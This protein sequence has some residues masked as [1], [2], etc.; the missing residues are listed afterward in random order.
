MPRLASPPAIT[1]SG[2]WDDEPVDADQ[3]YYDSLDDV[4]STTGMVFL[5]TTMGC[6]R[7]HDHKIDPIPQTRL[8]SD[9]GVLSQHLP[10]QQTARV[11]EDRVYAQ[12][13]NG[14]CRSPGSREPIAASKNNCETKSNSC[15]RQ[16][17]KFEERIVA[18]L[19][20]S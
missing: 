5:G 16:V 6:A 2:L 10:R 8:L 15:S 18:T 9:A 3:A 11:Q 17:D 14:H 1:D 7:C 12:Y 19:L 20:E 4:V 13:A